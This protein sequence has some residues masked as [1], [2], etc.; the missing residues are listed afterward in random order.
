MA[1]RKSDL[2][3]KERNILQ[4]VVTLLISSLLAHL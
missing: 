2:I 3:A 1:V 4:Q